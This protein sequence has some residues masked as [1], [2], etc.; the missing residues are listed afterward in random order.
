MIFSDHEF[1]SNENFILY[2]ARYYDNINCHHEKEFFDDLDRIRYIKNILT[3]SLTTG[4]LKVNV[5]LNHIIV[6]SNMFGPYHLPR[7]LYLKF[8]DEMSRIKPFLIMLKISPK[9]IVN[10]GKKL[11]VID[12]DAIPL[13][14]HV[15]EEL[16]KI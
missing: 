12:F 6:L 15:V 14:K 8:P 5:I 7:I 10:V 3:R 9:E 13:D 16:R 2:C 11:S 4:T 1:L